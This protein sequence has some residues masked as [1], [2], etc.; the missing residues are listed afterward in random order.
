MGKKK[1]PKNWKEAKDNFGRVYYYNT[2][3]NETST[4]HPGEESSRSSR[5]SSG[6]QLEIG[7][8]MN[9]RHE[10]HIGSQGG[11][12]QMSFSPEMAAA[13]ATQDLVNSM[14]GGCGSR[15]RGSEQSRRGSVM[16]PGWTVQRGGDGRPYY[17][18]AARPS[19]RTPPLAPRP[20]PTRGRRPPLDLAPVG[21]RQYNERTGET[22]WEKPRGAAAPPPRPPG[23]SRG[24][25]PPGGML[26]PGWEEVRD[27]Y[28][29]EPYCAPPPHTAHG[30]PTFPPPTSPPAVTRRPQQG[31]G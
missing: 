31:D 10:G 1:L 4:D 17:V 11:Q 23:S 26:P 30:P 12:F 20:A 22:S 19:P 2:K 28:G 27:P 7:L 24:P 25:P 21:A 6:R 13:G 8:P 14:R 15:G 16:P 9:V 18:R 5:D 3:T 29:G